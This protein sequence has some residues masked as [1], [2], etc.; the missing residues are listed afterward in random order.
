MGEVVYTASMPLAA[1][2]NAP[3]AAARLMTTTC[4]LMVG[5]MEVSDQQAAMNVIGSRCVGCLMGCDGGR[6]V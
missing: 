2:S 5:S 3:D 1:T 6:E 4:N